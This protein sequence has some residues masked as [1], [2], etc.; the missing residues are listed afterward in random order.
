MTGVR[1]ILQIRHLP[2][3]RSSHLR[4]FLCIFLV[5]ESER[6]FPSAWT[7]VDHDLL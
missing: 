3:H 1:L 2:L 5:I 7:A 6:R 4:P